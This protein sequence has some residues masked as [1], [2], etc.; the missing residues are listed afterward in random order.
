MG[1]IIYIYYEISIVFS[2]HFVNSLYASGQKSNMNG[3][4]I[5]NEAN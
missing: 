1:I 5:S 3:Q 4:K 2:F